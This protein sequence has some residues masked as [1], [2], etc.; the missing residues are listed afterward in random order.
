MTEEEL[1]DL[2]LEYV[3]RRNYFKFYTYYFI[4]DV[5]AVVL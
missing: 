5:V 4:A 2:Y 3:N 1:Y